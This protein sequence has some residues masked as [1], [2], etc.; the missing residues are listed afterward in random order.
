MALHDTGST[1]Q[2]APCLLRSGLRM[3]LTINMHEVV[4]VR[5]L[6]FAVYRGVPY[7]LTHPNAAGVQFHR[8]HAARQRRPLYQR[9]PA[10]HQR[11]AV[12]IVRYAA[13]YQLA[14]MS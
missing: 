2:E 14:T 11:V 6:P 5:E 1:A 9:A 3:M 10:R 8:Q 13:L 4:G 7:K 12:V